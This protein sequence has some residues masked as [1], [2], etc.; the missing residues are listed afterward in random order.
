MVDVSSSVLMMMDGGKKCLLEV[1]AFVLLGQENE[2]LE[3]V[4][5]ALGVYRRDNPVL[6]CLAFH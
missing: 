1:M 4:S 3:D 5:L 2:G 6:Q